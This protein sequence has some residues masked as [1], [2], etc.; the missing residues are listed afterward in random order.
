MALVYS[1]LKFVQPTIEDFSLTETSK[2]ST[3]VN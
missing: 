3:A 2:N 1:L